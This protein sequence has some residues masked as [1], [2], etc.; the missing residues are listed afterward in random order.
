MRYLLMLLL[1]VGF[2]VSHCSSPGNGNCT[3][4]GNCAEQPS[5]QGD[6]GEKKDGVVSTQPQALRW[7][8][9]KS[10][11][12]VD[13][14]GVAMPTAQHVWVVGANGTIL[15]SSD[16]GATWQSQKSGVTNTL[17]ALSFLDTS[18]GWIVGD[19]GVILQTED[20][21]KTW[22]I[23]PS[24]VTETLW[25]VQFL[26]SK[27][28]YAVGDGFSLLRTSDGG[29]LWNPT[30]FRLEI[31]LHGV[32]FV[33]EKRGYIVGSNGTILRTEDAAFTVTTEST[34]S[35]QR[36]R[37][38]HFLGDT[39]WAVGEH[40]QVLS[41]VKDANWSK[42][43]Q[44]FDV[45]FYGVWFADPTRG[46]S[47]G[48]YGNI[49]G[50]RD[51]GKTWTQEARLRYPNL[52]AIA[53]FSPQAG[54]IV[55]QSGTILRLEEVANECSHDEKRDCYTGPE[56]TK[57]VGR[58][59]AGSQRCIEGIWAP[60][61][62]EVKP[63]SQEIC[64]NDQDDNCNGKSDKDDKC[65]DCKDGDRRDC[66]S[67]KQGTQG[68]GTC[69]AGEQFCRN[70]KW[71][72]CEDEVLP[73]EEKCNGADDDC[74]GQVDNNP[75]S[76][77]PC[78]KTLGVCATARKIC[79][80]GRWQPCE[81]SQY[82]SD[83]QAQEDKC[84]G[85]DN[86][87]DGTI[88]ENCPC[89]KEGET[90]SCYGGAADTLNKGE[91][92]AG[93]QSCTQGKW[94]ECQGEIVP[95]QEICDDQ[96]DNDCDGKIDEKTQYALS[97]NGFWNYVLV[98]TDQALE[99]S[100]AITVEGWFNFARIASRSPISLVSKAEEGGYAI[101]VHRPTTGVISFRVWPKDGRDFVS[102]SVST[103]NLLSTGKWHHIAGTY[104]GQH[105]RLWI[106]GKKVAETPLA[107]TI[108]Y[109]KKN[110]PLIFGAEAGE[111]GVPRMAGWY[112]NGQIA[113]VRLSSKAVYDQDFSPDCL[114]AKTAETLG[115]WL[116][117][118]GSGT[119]V[120]D[121]TGKHHGKW[122]GNVWEEAIR[123]PG[124]VAGGGCQKAS[125]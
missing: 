10:P 32:F 73:A 70:N 19:D 28:G 44:E 20:G 4:E 15:A 46:W 40:G 97:L 81:A 85:K 94:T 84:D 64:F 118:E 90:R 5:S 99:P 33:N 82:G 122:E 7:N 23:L 38:I 116:F 37:A 39:G 49:L 16:G 52:H 48:Q 98:P 61:E 89:T 14:W 6:G 26:D 125:P 107:S 30:S 77:P 58:C 121:E 41:K 22:K 11:V 18:R 31:D 63:A 2:A 67:G 69:L 92:K 124:F 68:V 87:C 34:A 105:V 29:K 120:N 79:K 17:R 75:V 112:L 62:G 59:K 60:C 95:K 115:L 93:S 53:A 42:A 117:S 91:C 108:A 101:H 109:S 80:D 1:V 54:V 76:P 119:V 51:G 83:Y 66:Y 50:T 9:V 71:D 8:Q 86:D 110:I 12:Q 45:S 43:K 103:R 113:Q 55:G 56:A 27:T 100:D 96:K 25:G 123:C 102:A 24:P 78:D 104:N 114:L 111:N 21:G 3:Q 72:T 13:L 88:D 47:V 35:D 65:P 36:F 74:D 57:G 106:D